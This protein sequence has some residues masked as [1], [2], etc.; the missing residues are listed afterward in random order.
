MA[1]EDVAELL[2]VLNADDQATE[3]IDRAKLAVTEYAAAVDAANAQ[4]A[5]VQDKS[6]EA[7]NAI[8]QGA[9]DTSDALADVDHR[10]GALDQDLG[11]LTATSDESGTAS[12]R[13]RQAISDMADEISSAAAEEDQLTDAFNRG[14]GQADKLSKKYD[15]LSIASNQLSKDL[16][17]LRKDLG[18]AFADGKIEASD[19]ADYLA[20][21]DTVLNDLNMDV[22]TVGNDAVDS[23]G[24]AGTAVRDLGDELRKGDLMA[25]NMQKS[26]TR[27]SQA[28]MK[29]FMAGITDLAEMNANLQLVAEAADE[30]A[31]ANE[32]LGAVLQGDR[33]AF[34]ILKDAIDENV[35]VIREGDAAYD[36]FKARFEEAKNEVEQAVGPLKTFTDSAKGIGRATEDAAGDVKKLGSTAESAGGEM[37]FFS[38]VLIG[39]AVLA[40]VLSGALI[41]VMGG[42]FVL[43]AGIAQK[44]NKQMAAAFDQL[45][46]TIVDGTKKATAV[47][48]PTFVTAFH[49]MSSAL[50]GMTPEF[51]QLFTEMKPVVTALANAVINFVQGALPGLIAGFRNFAPL[52]AAF[53]AGMGEIGKGFGGIF[54]TLSQH[55]P[56]IVAGTQ[57]FFT[58]L[59][60]LLP[61]IALMFGEVSDLIGPL[62]QSLL[63]DIVQ[64][65]G[66]ILQALAPAFVIVG[67]VLG[68]F[69]KAI[70]P[71]VPPL[72]QLARVVIGAVVQAIQAMQPAW[73][74]LMKAIQPLIPPLQQLIAA[75]IKIIPPVAKILAGMVSLG[76]GILSMVLPVISKLIEILIE[77]VTWIVDRLVAPLDSVANH[78]T[79]FTSTISHAFSAA[80]DWISQ[81]W[82]VTM[83]TVTNAFRTAGAWITNA[84][85]TVGG[86]IAGVFHAISAAWDS[87]WSTFGA[88]LRL[89]I[90]LAEGVFED[91]IS[92]VLAIKDKIVSFFSG[93]AQWLEDAGQKI[94]EGLWNGLKQAWHNVTSWLSNVAG[95][96]ANLKGPIDKDAALLIPHGNAVMSGFLKGLQAGSGPVKDYLKGFTTGI[97]AM[98][99]AT[100]LS[101]SMIG[102]GAALG[103][104]GSGNIQV[105]FTGNQVMND[106]SIQQLANAAGRQIAKYMMPQAGR[107]IRG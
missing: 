51:T 78:I 9:Q 63:P 11:K 17:T 76:A 94:I 20:R 70:Q 7:F 57:G 16:R 105:V 13:V 8:D 80:G 35:E 36:D 46:D 97:G 55:M 87:F 90:R 40:P 93:A 77:L 32:R 75:L 39:M 92:D 2:I 59:G 45:K 61:V 43:I 5:S 67:D 103:G 26:M 48:V 64:I 33:S 38:K 65:A 42:A 28:G 79:N 74:A 31:A 106:Q 15:S 96:V 25:Q 66:V 81:H 88:A 71:L 60:Q 86:K 34:T 62:E 56:S 52:G 95:W 4:M 53:A 24:R 27:L 98:P 29:D 23:F 37:G 104:V 102:G 49:D 12:D 82:T 50:K 1:F 85:D 6:T 44:S 100:S 18:Q 91:F 89:G 14:V 10:T 68:Q 83:D 47:L 19:L 73:A 30:A 41:G 69:M 54:Q 101:A 58:A 99:L 72:E 21:L 3:K 84:W 22:R 107:Y